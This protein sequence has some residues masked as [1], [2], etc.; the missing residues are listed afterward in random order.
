MECIHQDAQTMVLKLCAMQGN[1][2]V[3]I[4]NMDTLPMD[5]DAEVAG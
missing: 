2:D 1:K 3:N 4:D 5:L